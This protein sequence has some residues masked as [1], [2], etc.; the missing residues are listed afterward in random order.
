M[1][2]EDAGVVIPEKNSLTY[3]GKTYH[4]NYI[5]D[6]YKVSKGGNSTVFILSDP[7]GEEENKVIKISNIYAVDRY[8]NER[9]KRRYGRFINEI[10][11]LK[12]IKDQEISQN[13]IRIEFDDVIEIDGKRFPYYVMEKADCDLKDY[14]LKNGNDVDIQ[15]RIKL[16]IDIYKGIKSL[17]RLGFYHRDIKPDNILLLYQGEPEDD[18]RKFVWKVGDLGLIAHREKD[19]DDIGEKIGPLG[20]L[21]PEAMNKFLTEKYKLGL[22]CRID[23]LSDIFQ[24]GK[25]FWFIFMYNVPIGQI[26]IDDFRKD[27]P[28]HQFIF[29]L[30]HKMLQ[31]S[32][33]NRPVEEKLNEDL[34]LLSIEFGI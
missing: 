8:S 19:D 25:L 34:E 30:L 9:F 24:L 13:V 7:L 5:N 29:N 4:L 20:W 3:E 12:K 31:Y 32:K 28:N 27:I 11:A 23:E 16:C 10:D 21:S 15:E 6:D 2:T 22:D 26:H 18:G 1:L 17:H 14:L 33:I